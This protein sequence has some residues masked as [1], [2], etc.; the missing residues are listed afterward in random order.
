M[1]RTEEDIQS[2]EE[3]DSFTSSYQAPRGRFV[4]EH[5]SEGRPARIENGLCQASLGESGGVHVAD[6]DVIELS[7]DAGRELVVKVTAGIGDARVN[8]PRL[9]SFACALSGSELA[10]QLPQRPRVLDLL[11]GG[12]G[13]KFLKTQVDANTA[14]HRPSIGLSESTTMFKNQR[15][16]ASQ[17]K[18]VPSLI[19]PSGS[20][21]ERNTRKVSPEKR[22]ASPSPLRF[23][24]SSGTQPKERRPRQR[25][26]GRFLWRR[27]LAYRSHTALIVPACRARSLLLPA[28]KRLRSKPLGQG[29]FHFSAC[30]CVS[31][32]KFQTKLQA[33][34]CI[35]SSPVR[36]L[37]RYR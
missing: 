21:R 20:G 1:S 17:E 28:V 32:Q 3:N 18:F 27:D 24:P 25:R 37:M 31:L 19:L 11:S 6:G 15:P 29:L 2:R 16:H 7:N 14:A 36:D 8:V 22:K 35:L 4:T 12:E 33:R 9:T 23:L 13:R 5:A 26:K 30:C 10:S 34:A